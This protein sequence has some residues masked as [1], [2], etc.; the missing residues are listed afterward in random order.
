MTKEELNS[1]RINYLVW[2][3]LQ[4]SNYRETAVKLQSEW[5]VSDPQSLDF[6]PHVNNHALVAVLQRGLL[7]HEAERLS[8]QSR[9]GAVAAP[10]AT[11]FFGPVAPLSPPL[12]S[13]DEI[14]NARKRSTE[15]RS[16]QARQESPAK[17][18]KL[19]N[20][21]ENGIDSTTTPMDL[22]EAAPPT[23]IS[24]GHAYPSPREVEVERVPT[25]APV[26]SGPE[27]GTQIEKVA[28]LS[29][30]TTYL[31]LAQ[32]SSTN[33]PI[34]L[35]CEWN[36][37]DPKRLATAGMDTLA[38]LWTVPSRTPS[39]QI[40]GH[41]PSPAFRDLVDEDEHRAAI[42][43]ISWTSDGE[44]LAVAS[45]CDGT[46]KINIWSKDGSRIVQFNS[47][48]Y[49]PVICLRW[50]ASDRTLLALT[51]TDN[52]GASSWATVFTTPNQESATFDL[53]PNFQPLDA[54]WTGPSDFVVCNGESLSGFNLSDEGIIT[55]TKTYDIRKE[56]GPT[57]LAYDP[58]CNLLAAA[59]DDGVI[60]IFDSTATRVG[61]ATHKGAVT[62]MKW[63][64][65]PNSSDDQPE[66]LLASSSE[67][68]SI[69]IWNSRSD[70]KKPV[71]TMTMDAAV[72]ALAFT[73]DGAFVAA[74]TNSHILI[75]SMADPSFPRARWVRGQEPGWQSPKTNGAALEEYHHCLVWD[76]DGKRLAYGVNSMLAVIK[77]IPGVTDVTVN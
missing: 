57:S 72:L 19:S 3:Y 62:S 5:D 42:S 41:V 20:G 24:N 25:P 32:T 39:P 69:N 2:R 7:Y 66:R 77:F 13:S 47:L 59:N 21:Y 70:F 74:T 16:Q 35:H 68:G 14:A 76:S 54:V 73:P 60:D 28:E 22:D 52:K 65:I 10:P 33:H 75:W 46:G 34:L 61:M 50:G 43:A 55:R 30:E 53:G 23:A 6:A 9:R 29:A 26:T 4:E 64:P 27:K 38:R 44:A 12:A 36:P 48:G 11:G 58:H 71:E 15:E 31:T 8:A 56:A 45:D 40:D 1:D 18:T 67:D 49:P 37:R 17:R 63:Q 51:S